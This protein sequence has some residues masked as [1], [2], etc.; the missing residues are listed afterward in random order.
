MLLIKAPKR[1]INRPGIIKDAGIYIKEYGKRAY[2]IGGNTS[3]SVVGEEFYKSL[4][5]NEV[6]YK[7][8]V[9]Q[10][11]PTIKNCGLHGGEAKDFKA[12]VIIAVGGG[13]V[14]DVAKV[15]GNTLKLPVI[16]VPTIAATC[17]SW[18]A[19]SIIYDGGGNFESGIFNESTPDLIIADTRIIL[20]APERYINA[21][22][23]DTLAKWYEINPNKTIAGKNIS[24]S[25]MEHAAELAFNV[26]K[27]NGKTA[28]REAEKGIIGDAAVQT[29]DAVIYLAGL[30]GAFTQETFFGGFAHPFYNESTKIPS[31]RHRLHGEK[32]A[33]GLLAQLVLENKPQ[34]YIEETIREFAEYGL[35]LT[36]EDIGIAQDE[37]DKIASI[38]KGVITSLPAFLNFASKDKAQEI[39]EAIWKTDHLVRSVAKKSSEAS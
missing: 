1:Y 18:A 38:A 19:V 29:V 31:T 17:A 24:F 30:A 26:L 9:L 34:E 35:A 39:E 13:R 37:K 2:L 6:L 8:S 5:E 4:S 7:K 28:V 15:V 36:L 11:Y 12:D 20:S 10:G 22:I 32:V 14:H 21:G 16:A 33:F 23:L 25:V 3:F 27:E